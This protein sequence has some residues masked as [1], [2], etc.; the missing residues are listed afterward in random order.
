MTAQEMMLP[1]FGVVVDRDA[2]PEMI[3]TYRPGDLDGLVNGRLVVRPPQPLAFPENV[4]AP[5]LRR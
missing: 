2:Q 3:A 1:W 5:A 4:Q